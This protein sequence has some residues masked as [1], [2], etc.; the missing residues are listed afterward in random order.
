M[1][2]VQVCSSCKKEMT[3]DDQRFCGMHDLTECTECRF[4]TANGTRT[5]E[6]YNKWLRG[7]KVNR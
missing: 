2:T 4:H 6:N 7:E 5:I 1:M 3:K